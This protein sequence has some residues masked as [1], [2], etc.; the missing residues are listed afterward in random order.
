MV[1]AKVSVDD[2]ALNL[3]ELC[4]MSVVESLVAEHSIYREEL[5]RPE[6]LLLSDLFQVPRRNSSCMSPKDVLE[7][8]LRLPLVVIP[9]A[10]VASFLVHFLHLLEVFLVLNCGLLW[11]RDEEGIVGISSGMGLRLEE[12]V[13]VPEG[14]FHVT[15]SVHFLEAHL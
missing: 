5:P 1:Q 11:M 8:F 2:K 14:A 4:K 7:G 13:E 15:V 6:W 12:G 9:A 3:M 10:S